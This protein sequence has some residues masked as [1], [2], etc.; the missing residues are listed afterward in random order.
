MTQKETLSR[1]GVYLFPWGVSRPTTSEIVTSAV[2]ADE[3]GFGSVHVAWHFTQP[4]KNIDNTHNLDPLVVVPLIAQ[5]TSNVRVAINSVIFP[6]MHPYFWA[7]YFANLDILSGG[8]AIACAALGWAPDDFRVGLSKVKERGK[9]FD[10]ALA[11]YTALCHGEEIAEPGAFWD[12]R[13]LALH[14][15]PRPDLPL[16]VGGGAPSLERAARWAQAYNP[17]RLD[18]AAI[19]DEIRPRLTEAAQAHGRSVDLVV[20]QTCAIV[21]PGDSAEWQQENVWGPLE[22]RPKDRD[23]TGAVIGSPQECADRISAQFEAGVDEILLEFDFHG[24]TPSGEPVLRQMDR[25]VEHVLP[26]IDDRRGEASR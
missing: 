2:H 15:A 3:L 11:L 17:T 4:D 21:L 13:A 16:W 9:R 8:R 20:T 10:E 1:L 7:R 18:V 12:A 14:P 6:T 26:L 22:S 25:F 19:R 5:A 24:A 23:S